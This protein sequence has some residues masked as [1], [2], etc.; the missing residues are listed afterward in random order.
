MRLDV[1]LVDGL[2]AELSLYY[3]VG[4]L[5]SLIDAANLQPGVAGHVIGELGMKQRCAVG[6]SVL[7]RGYHGQDFVLHVD[8][9]ER[10]F[11]FVWAVR[12]HCGHWMALEEHLATSEDLAADMEQVLRRSA[13]SSDNRLVLVLW[14]VGRS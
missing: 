13:R 9:V 4:L 2:G 8:Q 14:Q 1:S 11:G 6:H 5:E 7:D 10:L 3:D 12:S